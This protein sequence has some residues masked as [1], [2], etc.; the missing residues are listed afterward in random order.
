MP[1]LPKQ[2]VQARIIAAVQEGTDGTRSYAEMS[3]TLTERELDGMNRMKESGLLFY[4][5][6]VEVKDQPAQLRV[7]VT[8][9]PNEYL[10]QE[11]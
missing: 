9:R 7:S 8:P 2:D 5:F 3:E 10:G 4:F 6:R 1:A 11:S